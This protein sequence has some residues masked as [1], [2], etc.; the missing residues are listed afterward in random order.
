[1]GRLR[2]MTWPSES[3]KQKER[4]RE[5]KEGFES[6]VLDFELSEDERLARSSL[7]GKD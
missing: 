2:P 1:M 3:E 4:E 7:I 5:R 6:G